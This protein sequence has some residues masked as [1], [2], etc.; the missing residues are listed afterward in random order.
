MVLG[1]ALGDPNE[2]SD[3]LL[4]QLD[5]SGR[6]RGVIGRR[7]GNFMLSKPDIVLACVGGLRM[8]SARSGA[9]ACGASAIKHPQCGHNLGDFIRVKTP[10]V[11]LT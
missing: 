10:V 9:R 8:R 2:V 1:D 11:T 5:V 6:E 7:N 4:L 3:L